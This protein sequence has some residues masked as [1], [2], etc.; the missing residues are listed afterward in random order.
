VAGVSQTNE[1]AAQY[2]GGISQPWET[3]S[4]VYKTISQYCEMISQYCGEPG[5]GGEGW[6]LRLKLPTQ[7]GGGLSQYLKMISQYWEIISQ[8]CETASQYCG[9]TPKVWE[10]PSIYCEMAATKADIEL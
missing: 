10:M 1:V 2:L 6:L 7:G 9:T 8:G 3:I 5:Q 4:Q